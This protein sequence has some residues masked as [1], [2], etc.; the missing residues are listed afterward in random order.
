MHFRLAQDPW[1][2]ESSGV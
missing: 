2:S 1:D